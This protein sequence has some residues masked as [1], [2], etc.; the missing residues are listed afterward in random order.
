MGQR[1]VYICTP[2]Q[3]RNK[4]YRLK[5][6]KG[7]ESMSSKHELQKHSTQTYFLNLVNPN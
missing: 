2:Y 3:V 7:M 1:F 6:E 4:N 5:K